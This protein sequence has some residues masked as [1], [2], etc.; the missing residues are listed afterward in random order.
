MPQA[1][2][3]DADEVAVNTRRLSWH[4]HCSLGV[5]V[6]RIGLRPSTRETASRPGDGR[7]DVGAL[8]KALLAAPQSLGEVAARPGAEVGG[9]RGG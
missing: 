5:A 1:I 8:L 3:P 9:V 4:W 2:G 7:P 6:A